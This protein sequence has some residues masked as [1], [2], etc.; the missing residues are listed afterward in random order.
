MIRKRNQGKNTLTIGIALS[1]LSQGLYAAGTVSTTVLDD[2]KGFE[3]FDTDGDPYLII[4]D[5]GTFSG[6]YEIDMTQGAGG[7]TISDTDMSLDGG[8]SAPTGSRMT[9]DDNGATLSNIGNGQPITL[10]G[11]A[12]GESDYDA[13]NYRQLSGV[14]AAAAAMAAVPNINQNAPYG[15]GIGT[16]SYDGTQAVA[17]GFMARPSENILVEV[18]VS[19]AFSSGLKPAFS[20]GASWSFGR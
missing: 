1:M 3:W 4:N 10:T 12:D 15:F 18:N 17:A 2:V 5:T 7:L 13:T 9:L 14:A 20:A 6:D 16:G 19:K 8:S 11:V